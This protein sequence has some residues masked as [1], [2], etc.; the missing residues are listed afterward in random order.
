MKKYLLIILIIA[1]VL[2]FYGLNRGDT[3]NDEVFYAF[4]AIG[5]MDF[6]KAPDQTTPPEWFDGHIPQWVNLSFHDHPPL[7]FWVQH[8]FMGVFGESAWAFRLP[9]AILAVVSVWLVYLIGGI[10]FSE[11]A[12][13]IS[14][15]FF[16][17]TLNNVY[18]S[19]TGMQESY[20]IFFMLLAGYLFLKSFK[21]ESYLIWT[22][23]ALGLGF[24]AKYNVFIMAP[25]FLGYLLI[26]K[27]AYFLN[28]K[29]WLGALLALLIF[30]PVIIYN[31]E[32]YR[33]VGH[34][35]F[36]LSYIFRQ[37]H[38]EWVSE[39]GKEIGSF[40]DRIKNFIPRLISTN[41]WL[42]LILFAVS[43]LFLRNAFLFLTLTFLLL[44]LTLIGP[45]YRFLTMLT[46]WMVLSFGG[47]TAKWRLNRLIFLLIPILAFEIFYSY[48]NQIAYYPNGPTTWLSSKVRY[49]NYNWGYDALNNYLEKEL[50]GKMPALTFYPKY[51]FL[52]KL[53]DDAL[54]EARQR[55][56]EPDPALLV[57]YGN[58][59]DGARLWIFDRLRFYHA[60]PIISFKEYNDFMKEKGAD[61]YM[62]SGFKNYYFMLSTNIVPSAE[63]QALIKDHAPVSI[64]NHR[65][66]EVF[67][68]YKF[69]I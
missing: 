23:L 6:D 56:L 63:F 19:R 52:N 35:D 34:F 62:K 46:P 4:R 41:S 9:S 42:F 8:F 14:S 32:M 16:A 27:R 1:A 61:Y 13:L 25:I 43:L 5:L 50:A 66:D 57:Y 69:L 45:S 37:A 36:Q 28:K 26:Y 58:I 39:P 38:P 53:Q 54:T 64:F 17:V 10:L 44:L 22:G 51:Q 60:W 30:S 65:G 33:A 2:R 49:E 40:S 55:N 12:G 15:A 68:I 20:V 11:T 31:Y 47:L 3:V 29:F 59:D 48:N 21:K 7:V 18:I 67:K 24:L